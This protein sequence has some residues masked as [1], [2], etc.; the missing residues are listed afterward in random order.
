MRTALVTGVIDAAT[1]LAEVAAPK[2][3]ASV[4][5]VGAVRESN[6]GREVS[7]IE[8]SAYAAMAENEMAD[9]V[10]EAA[11]QFDTDDIVV[12]HRVGRL[13][14]GEASVVIAV[15]HPHRAQAYEASRFIIEALKKRVPVWK[16]EEYLDGT[17]E[18]V[19]PTTARE[20]APR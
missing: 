11:S 15:A 8:Y 1:L 6:D 17:R 3:G 18:W 14:I 9:I 12:E 19:D 2:N 5:F 20:A 13:G 16:R 7:G 4:L 10:S